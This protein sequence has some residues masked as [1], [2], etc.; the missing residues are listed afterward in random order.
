MPTITITMENILSDVKILRKP[1]FETVR[2]NTKLSFIP[3]E[4]N[5]VSVIRNIDQSYR[6]AESDVLFNYIFEW[7]EAKDS[8]TA[9]HPKRLSF[10]DNIEYIN[11]GGNDLVR[12]INENKMIPAYYASSGVQSAMPLDVMADYF[13]GLVGKNASIWAKIRN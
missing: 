5:L 9:E 2:Y 13:T 6:S 1:E 3:S 11:D 7:G 10:T 4:R 12:L 8:Y